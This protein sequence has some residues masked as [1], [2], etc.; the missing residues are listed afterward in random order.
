MLSTLMR[1]RAPAR[2]QSLRIPTSR[3]LGTYATFKIP[4]INNEP[5]VC[6]GLTLLSVG[7]VDISRNTM[8]PVRPIA[9]D[10]RMLWLHSSRKRR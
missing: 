6:Y 4:Q 5:N 9:R 7:C 3:A 2:A 1:F 10:S 8:F